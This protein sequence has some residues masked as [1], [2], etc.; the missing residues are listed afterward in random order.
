MMAINARY[1]IRR[2][3]LALALA[4]CLCAFACQRDIELGLPPALST[5][6]STETN[7]GAASSEAKNQPMQSDAPEESETALP[8]ASDETDGLPA[9]TGTQ[10]D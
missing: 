7:D 2:W 1:G 5:D 4:L 10:T 3:A 6:S 8:P 9:D